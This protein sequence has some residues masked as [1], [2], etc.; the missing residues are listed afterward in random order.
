[1]FEIL[2]DFISEALLS[3]NIFALLENYIVGKKI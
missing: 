2:K 3:L 1:M